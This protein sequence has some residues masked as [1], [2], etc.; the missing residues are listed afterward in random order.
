MWNLKERLK[1]GESLVGTM[2]IALESPEMAKILKVSGFDFFIVDAEH[3]SFDYG[4]MAG[5]LTVAR[6]A[7]ITPMVRIPEARRE[8]VLKVMEMGAR[9]ILLPNAE[10][11]E[12]AKALVEYSKY[13]PLGNRGVSLFRPATGFEKVGNAVEYMRERNEENILMVQ[14]ES[15]K[16]VQNVERMLNVEGI[17]A[18][19]IGPNDLSQTMGIMG[20]TSHPDFIAA[21]DR[22]IEAARQRK[23]FSGVHM[24]SADALLP[25]IKKGMT[26]NLWSNEVLLMMDA[27]RDGLA[28]L[29]R[30]EP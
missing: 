21:V 13:Y 2:V 9:G 14:I 5:I 12:Q 16:G 27:A 20:Q 3:G 19:F 26:L 30:Q 7:G 25:W 22:V 28:R 15:P 1:K 23:K 4:A 29:R 24:M 17:D 11:V 18:A 8:V 6:E 10:T